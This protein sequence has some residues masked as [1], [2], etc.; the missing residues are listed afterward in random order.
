LKTL[1]SSPHRSRRMFPTRTYYVRSD[2]QAGKS[3]FSRAPDP[4][5]GSISPAFTYFSIGFTSVSTDCAYQARAQRRRSFMIAKNTGTSMR[6]LI[7]EVIM[8]PTIGAAIGFIT[9]EPI[10]LSHRIGARLSITTATVISL[11]RRR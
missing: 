3:H 7:V 6:T 10:P 11:G 2:A 9:S 4:V 8:P 5:G 1:V